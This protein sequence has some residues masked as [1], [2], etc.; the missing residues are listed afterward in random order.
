MD[1]QLVARSALGQARRVVQPRVVVALVAPTDEQQLVG[2]QPDRTHVQVIGQLGDGRHRHFVRQVDPLRRRLQP[3]R[4]HRLQRPEIDPAGSLRDLLDPTAHRSDPQEPVDNHPRRHAEPAL[5]HDRRLLAAG[6]DEGQRQIARDLPVVAGVIRLLEE[7][8]RPA[9]RVAHGKSVEDQ[10]V[11]LPLQRPGRRQDHVRVPGRLVDI[12]VDGDHE[13]E[14]A[15]RL[16]QPVPA[17]RRRHWV[18][19]DRHQAS[20]LPLPRGQDLV[21]QCRHRKLG[22]E[23]RQPLC[24]RLPRPEVPGRDDLV[25]DEINRR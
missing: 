9:R 13:V 23:L 1:E 12:D 2:R 5:V 17:G 19:G 16:V 20:D 22:S 24:P 4:Q 25:P 7:R 11:V 18:A 3:V 21:G 8:G 14:P 6:P 10:V 15:Q